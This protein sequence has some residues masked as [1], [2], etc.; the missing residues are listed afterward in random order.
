MRLR[1]GY[2]QRNNGNQA[3]KSTEGKTFGVSRK[4]KILS[5]ACIVER[6]R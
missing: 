3:G 4:L 1:R 5:Q 2:K 6:K